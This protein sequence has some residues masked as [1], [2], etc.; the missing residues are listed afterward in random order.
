MK[1]FS[2]RIV[3]ADVLTFLLFLVLAA[4]IWYGHAMHSVRNTR[5]PVY[6]QYTGKPGSI[7]LG[8]E[9][10]P[11]KVMIEVRDAGLRLNTYHQEPLHLTIDLHSYIHGT[12]GTIHVPS[13]ALRR[14]ISDI[15]QGTSSLVETYP[16]EITCTY[17]TEQEKTVL[18]AFDGDISPAP[19]YQLVG[20]PKLNYTKIKLYGD[21]KTLNAID[22][23]YTERIELTEL[24]DTTIMRVALAVPDGTRAEKDSVDL[25]VITERFTEKKFK[26]PLR[27]IGV[28]E[29]YK[30]RVFPNEVEVNVRVAMRHFAQV[31]ASD[32]VATCTYTPDRTETL[33]VE[34][35]Y[36]NPSITSAWA[37]PAV[38]EFMLEQ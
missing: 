22:T 19:E 13:D 23:V 4:L 36:S 35:H 12:K 37:Y 20:V 17:F 24:M 7:G 11:D 14:S 27:T 21:E 10:L 2:H 34:I 16:D 31:Q 29:G 38:V 9:G 1:L 25:T 32:M 28:P 8:E 30:I 15:L 18:V 6:I 5:V 33:E 26:L 3:W